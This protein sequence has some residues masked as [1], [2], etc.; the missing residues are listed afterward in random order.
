MSLAPDTEAGVADAVCAATGPLEIVAGGTRRIGRPVNAADTLSLT[1]LT[2]ID[3]YEPGEQT[4]VVAAGTPLAEVEAALD[5]EGQ[6]LTFEPPDHRVL[7][8]TTGEPTIGGAAATASAGPRRLASGGVRD[9]VLGARI[10]TGDGEAIRS[11]GRVM[12]NVTGYDLARL[13]CGAHGTLGVLTQLSLKVA[14]KAEV[15]T[16]MAL[17][18]LSDEAAVAAMARAMGMPLDVSAAAHLPE[19][20]AKALGL[21]EATTLLRLEGFEAQAR[22]RAGRLA[23]ALAGWGEA[24]PLDDAPWA[25]I[26]D[27][28][29][30]AGDGR[31]VWRVSVKPSDGPRL[32]AAAREALG[33]EAFYDWA[34]GLV[35][36]ACE[37]GDDAGA[38]TIR[39][40]LNGGHATLIRAPEPLRAAIPVFEP[41]P[42]VLVRLGERLKAVFDPR[43]ILNPGRMRG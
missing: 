11:G 36:L 42:D 12:K 41:E 3:L 20:A 39:G 8:G 15:T 38:A 4:L 32:A 1:N 7:L 27:A 29:P 19:A 43:G 30:F 21:D 18:G 10:V 6:R 37:A 40:A 25:G 5:S 26:R 2:G 17:R 14:P 22:Y 16:T 33:A 34:G 24:A 35:W 13:M 9:A 23:E 31:A 28:A